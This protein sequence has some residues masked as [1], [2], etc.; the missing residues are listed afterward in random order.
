M[1]KVLLITGY[2][3]VGVFVCLYLGFLFVLPNVIDLNKYTPQI[4]KLVKENSGF[5]IDLQGLS[6]VTTP[7]LEV[8]IKTNTL[9]GGSMEVEIYFRFKLI[10]RPK[11]K[12][13][14]L[15]IEDEDN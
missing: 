6:L 14:T 8:G 4:Q 2:I 13:V 15:A 12:K 1:K 10:R 11:T 9:E 3:F 5:N 7:L